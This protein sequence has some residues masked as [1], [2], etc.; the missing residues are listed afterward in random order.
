MYLNDEKYINLPKTLTV[1]TK[2]PKLKAL[3]LENDNLKD[4][5]SEILQFKNL[6][7]LYL[8]QNHFKEI[9]KIEALDHLNYLDLKDND[10]NVELLDMKNLNFGF[11]INF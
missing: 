6:E 1:L 4:L 2:L 7:A 11:K 3:H 8:N 5:P 9:P 10:I